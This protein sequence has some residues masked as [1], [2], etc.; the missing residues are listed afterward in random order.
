MQPGH[1]L[2]NFA[3]NYLGLNYSVVFAENYLETAPAFEPVAP[4]PGRP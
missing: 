4:G 1:P 3:E 2:V